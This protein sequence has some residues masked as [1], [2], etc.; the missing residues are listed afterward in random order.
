VPATAD[1]ISEAAMWIVTWHMAT[2]GIALQL[3]N[4]GHSFALTLPIPVPVGG[5]L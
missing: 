1:G 3:Q 2:P 4:T 5:S